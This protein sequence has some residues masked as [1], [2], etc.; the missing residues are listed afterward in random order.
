MSLDLSNTSGIALAGTAITAAT[1]F[2]E[3][4]FDEGAPAGESTKFV[5]KVDTTSGNVSLD[6]LPLPSALSFIPDG[7]EVTF[8][9]TSTDNNKITADDATPGAA[10]SGFTGVLYEF[11]NRQGESLSLV[12]NTTDDN[13][14]VSI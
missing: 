13:W 8:I 2:A 14:T 1:A 7:A 12:A 11:V 6:T 10:F 3:S 9:K 4:I 5:V